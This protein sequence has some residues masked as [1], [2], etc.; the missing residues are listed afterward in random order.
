VTACQAATTATIFLARVWA[1]Q[2]RVRS[3]TASLYELDL[4]PLPE[5][6]GRH[7]VEDRVQHLEDPN[8]IPPQW[9]PHGRLAARS[10]RPRR[11]SAETWPRRWM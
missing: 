10:S 3:S 6:R 8:T 11:G 4:T 5:I 1:V 2:R 7:A 9:Q